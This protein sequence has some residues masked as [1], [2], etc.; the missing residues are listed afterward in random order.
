[1]NL[2]EIHRV[3]FI[4]IGGI[5]MSALARYFSRLGKVVSGY[6]KTPTPLTDEL[7]NEG[8]S[9]HF[10]DDI[11]Y[12][13]KVFLEK[14]NT[15]VVITP[16][17]PT[18]HKEWNFFQS[19]GYLVKKRSEVLGVITKETYCF[20]VAGTHG[21]TTTSAILGH[22]LHQSGVEVTALLGGIVN[23][24]NSNII[25][26]GTKVTVVEA[27]EFDRSFHH[28]HPN[29]ACVTSVDADHLD[30][31]GTKD[32]FEDSF[33]EFALRVPT[34]DLFVP[35]NVPLNG[36]R[37]EIGKQS[38]YYIPEVSIE[39][40]A[41][42]FNVITP[43]Q[44]L[45]NLK[46]QLPGRHNLMNTLTAVS[47]AESY[48]VSEEN[49]RNALGSFEG[50]QRR[51]SFQ[52]NTDELVYIDDYAH[53]PTEINAVYHAVKELYPDRKILVIFQPHL[54][55]RTRDFVDGFAESLS[56]FD[57]IALMEIY[58]ARELPIPGVDAL[59]LLNKIENK[60]KKL[61][62]EDNLL[63]TVLDSEARVILT[64]GAG[65]ISNWVEPIKKKLYE[66]VL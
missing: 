42:V 50:I 20:A 8:I 60:E 19:E 61:V 3:Y 25:G 2:N 57:E 13:P 27:D 10:V 54:F 49:I 32:A 23:N 1:M 31:Y 36:N 63:A 65:D 48:G 5:G 56:Q 24:Y 39:N 59:W 22:I 9:S 35:S 47:M 33:R 4:G 46:M 55:S 53:H 34:E 52:I 51:F 21:K 37:L 64:L 58:P 62:D 40:G 12:I 41:Y 29:K 15:L 44:V 18:N 16:A 43:R 14:Q 26:D 38:T 11:S 30:V 7:Y 28:L 45:K 66:K 17:I 6:D